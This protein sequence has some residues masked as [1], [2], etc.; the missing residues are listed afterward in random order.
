[1][2]KL[3]FL[4]IIFQSFCASS[5]SPT[6]I[7][8]NS[9]ETTFHLFD[10]IVYV[11]SNMSVLNGTIVKFDS[12]KKKML[13][14]RYV[15][16]VKDGEIKVWCANGNLVLSA[17]YKNGVPEGLFQWWYSNGKK[18]ARCNYKKGLLDGKAEA[19]YN[20]FEQL[21][22]EE[23][24]IEGKMIGNQRYYSEEGVFLGGG[25]LI[26]G[27]GLLE[28]YYNSKLKHILA[29]YKNG[30]LNGEVKY[31]TEHGELSELNNFRDGIRDGKQIEYNNGIVIREVNYLND[32]RNGIEKI[33]F[34]D[35]TYAVYSW[36]E[37][38]I[39]EVQY[40]DENNK[41]I[42]RPQDFRRLDFSVLS[43]PGIFDIEDHRNLLRLGMEIPG[44]WC[45][46]IGIEDQL[47]E[48]IFDSYDDIRFC[49]FE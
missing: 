26:D 48:Q 8:Y 11:R 44:F 20:T 28:Y 47:L 6:S 7:V 41:S 4:F 25:N 46:E 37:G 9:D 38:E 40:F 13:E 18:K 42:A 2:K 39:E 45:S 27:N 35:N 23:N 21:M 1:M 24:Y 31:F 43:D 22:Y 14:C 19:W 30:E 34:N 33:V 3:Y 29:T 16:G 17:N 36:K 12:E 5:Q 49:T 15:N 10:T 32:K